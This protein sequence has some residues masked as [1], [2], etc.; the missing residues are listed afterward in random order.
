MMRLQMVWLW[1]VLAYPGQCRRLGIIV[2]GF[3]LEAERWEEVVWGRPPEALGRLPAAALLAWE[4]RGSLVRVVCG[5]GASHAADGRTEGETI[6][7][8]LLSRISQLSDFD[9]FSCV[10]LD[11]LEALLRDTLLAES[12]SRNTAEEVTC[13]SLGGGPCESANLSPPCHTHRAGSRTV[14]PLRCAARCGRGSSS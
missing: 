6:V 5:T 1:S 2:H 14:L 13:R 3:H 7:E 8:Y 10:P 4:E 12:T 11:E 9:A